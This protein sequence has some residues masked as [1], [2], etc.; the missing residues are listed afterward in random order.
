MFPA[1]STAEAKIV[2]NQLMRAGRVAEGAPLV[3]HGAEQAFGKVKMAPEIEAV[4][5]NEAKTGRLSKAAAAVGGVPMSVD[6]PLDT[7]KDL[8]H[9]WQDN[10]VTPIANKLKS[11]LTPDLNVQG[12]TY[13]TS[14]PPTD[15]AMETIAN[16]INYV[17]GPAGVA[18]GAAEAVSQFADGGEVMPAG[19]IPIDQFQAAD[20]MAGAISVDQFESS[21]DAYGGI[22]QQATTFLEGAAEGVAGP[23]APMAEKALGVDEADILGRRTENAVTHG[24]GQAAGLGGSLLTGVG[25]GALMAKAGSAAAKAVGLGAATEGASLGF[26]IGSEAVKQAAEMGI[27]SGSDELSKMVLHDPEQS[28]QSAIANIGL[29]AAIGG[30]TGGVWAGAVSPLWKATNGLG[31]GKVLE[32]VTQHLNGTALIPS[33]AVDKATQKLGVQLSPEMRAGMSND[34]KAVEM[35]GRAKE[36]QALDGSIYQLKTDTSNAVARDLGVDVNQVATRSVSEEGQEL[37]GT[38]GDLFKGEAKPLADGFEQRQA[39]AAT[40]ALTDGTRL[41]QYGKMIEKGMQEVGTDS[42]AYKLYDHYGQ[43]LLAKENLAGVDIL[44]TEIGNEMRAAERAA[45][46]NKLNALKDIR[47]MLGDF[48]ESQITKQSASA[49]EGMLGDVGSKTIGDDVAREA[50]RTEGKALGAELINKRLELNRSYSEFA[51]KMTELGDHMGIGEFRGPSSFLKKIESLSPEQIASKFSFKGNTEFIP[52]LQKEFPQIYDIVK[53]NEIKNFLKSSV[54]S[55]KGEAAINVTK[56]ADAVAAANAKDTKYVQ[57]L[58]SPDQLEKI[59][60]GK[61]ILDAIPNPKSSGTAGWTAKLFDKVPASA[62]AAVAMVMGHNPLI[63]GVI[64]HTSQLLGHDLPNATRLAYL[65]FLGSSQPIKAEGFKAMVDFMRASM[66]NETQMSKAATSLFKAGAQVIPEHAFPSKAD[67][68]RLDKR[69]TALQKNPDTL[70]KITDGEVGHYLPDH[71]ASLAAGT[72]Q[73]AQY[74][75]KLKPQPH[76]IGPLDKEIPPQPSEVARYNRALTIANN[77]NVVFDHIKSGTLLKSD[78][79]DLT[80]LYP[81]LYTTMTQKITNAMTDQLSEEGVIPYKTRM[82]ISLFLGTPV[83][84]SM[85]PGSIMAAQPKPTQQQGGQQPAK[86]GGQKS[87]IGNKTNKMYM[88]ASQSAE[89]DRSGR[90]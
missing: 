15:F 7:L 37:K 53:Q 8:G 18:L 71:Q 42:P 52:F 11:T 38:F 22:G 23:L 84:A 34:P 55:A 35:F 54:L 80:S 28:A 70:T 64:G 13:K 68:E 10:V 88:T 67:N 40:I 65:K 66:R 78:I 90:D 73:A 6:T 17:P 14:S 59:A 33:E 43:R 9:K 69:I 36:T 30:A 63:G 1:A 82:G 87:K 60:A 77:P 58:F 31:V 25:E 79:Q 56:L 20:G 32:G 89:A 41:S 21:E 72:T 85:T 16:P 86:S 57:A 44:R 4:A 81:R 50:S 46:Y 49:A 75:M 29:G 76:R 26:R 51:S 2:A 3:E 45:D 47:S 19:A 74:L 27:L 5:N 24:L 12:Q 61:T 83:D 48:Q 62:M 39:E